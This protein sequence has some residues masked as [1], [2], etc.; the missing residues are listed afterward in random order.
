MPNRTEHA[1]KNTPVEYGV[2]AA[3]MSSIC[4]QL[5]L[6]LSHKRC[7]SFAANLF[8]PFEDH[9]HIHRQGP[10]SSHHQRLQRLHMHP[11]LPLVVHSAAGVEI[12][13]P[14]CRLK[15]R[16]RPLIERLRR[17][18]VVVPLAEYRRLRVPIC[19]RS[20]MKPLRIDQ[21]M[22]FSLSCCRLNQTNIFHPDTLQL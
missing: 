15:R 18:H 10:A 13:I 14:L 19:P 22:P 2:A 6:M 3:P 21:R 8:L 9:P 1:R 12:P 4:L 5:I 11:H 20:R 16:R 7:D 17:L